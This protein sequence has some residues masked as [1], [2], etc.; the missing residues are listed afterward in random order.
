MPHETLVAARAYRLGRIREQ[1][2]RHDAAGILLYDPVQH[3]LR[4]RQLEHAGLDH[5]QRHAATR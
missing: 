1:L 5:A 4:A 2:A 3:P